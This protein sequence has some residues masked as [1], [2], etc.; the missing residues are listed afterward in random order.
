MGLTIEDGKQG[1][2]CCKS[3]MSMSFWAGHPMP[4]LLLRRA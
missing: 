3:T 1:F 4:L 2:N